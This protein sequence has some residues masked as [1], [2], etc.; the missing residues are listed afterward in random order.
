MKKSIM[1]AVISIVL[2]MPQVSFAKI[3]ISD[4]DLAAITGQDSISIDMS[5]LRP[6]RNVSNLSIIWDDAD[7]F[8][9]YTDPGY[10]GTTDFTISGETTK[11]N[12]S[13][14]LDIT[15][16]NGVTLVKATTPEIIIG[17]TTG[18]N[19]DATIKLGTDNTLS[20][21]QTLGA[22]YVG[23]IKADIPPGQV[24]ITLRPYSYGIYGSGQYFAQ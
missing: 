24:T 21:T 22:L 20:G 11:F 17:G 10:F 12:G 15:Y 18:M 2:M 5:K 13:V 3:I 6:L 23:G 9:E 4:G 8:S 16:N 19:I 1:L 14:T 7:G